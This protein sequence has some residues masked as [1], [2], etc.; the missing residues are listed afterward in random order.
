MLTYIARRCLI[1]IPTLLGVAT[2]SFMLMR[3]IPGDPA[4]VMAGPQASAEQVAQLR[5]QLGLDDSL[6]AQYGKYLDR[7]LHGNLGT[8]ARTGSSVIS[9]ISSRA[10]FT[11]ELALMAMVIAVLLGCTLGIIAAVRRDSWLDAV[12]SA[13][14]VIGVSMPVYWVG[15]LF[16]LLFA[17]NLHWL[18]AAGAGSLSAY[19]LPSVTLSLFATGFISR[20]TRSSML[21]VL[22]QDFIRSARAKGLGRGAVILRHGLRNASL[23]VITVVG[24]QFGQLLGGAIL[25]ETIFAWPGIGRLLVDSIASRDYSTVQG[26][27]LLFAIALIVVNLAT[28]LLYSYVD[29]RI[30]YD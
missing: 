22:G 1:A 11:V 21:E 15:L 10:P 17:V 6:S 12:L 23:P 3:I 25:T 4:K 18:P 16:V 8:S 2:I 14:S 27:V 24:L 29:P 28:D 20:Q 30:R 9:E 7:L 19:V 5:H 26:V 13:V